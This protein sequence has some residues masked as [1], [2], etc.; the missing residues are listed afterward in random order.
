MA[1][2]LEQILRN[3]ED[4][5]IRFLE[6]LEGKETKAKVNLD[7]ISFKVGKTDVLVSGMVEFTVMPQKKKKR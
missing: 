5:I 3:N 6:I 7:G 2:S 4:L 1:N